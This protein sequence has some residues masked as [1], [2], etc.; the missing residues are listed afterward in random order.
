MDKIQKNAIKDVTNLSYKTL[1]S[2]KNINEI[3]NLKNE[4]DMQSD[5]ELET[6]PLVAQI[7]PLI[8]VSCGDINGIGLELILRNHKLISQYCK[9]IYCISM[10]LLQ[11]ASRLL[12]IAIASDLEV[13]HLESKGLSIQKG[14]AT[15]ESGAYSFDSF[16][17]A[18]E[19]SIAKNAGLLTLPINKYAWQLANIRY[20][21]HTEYLRKRFQKNA[22]MM[23][24]CEEMFV[25]LYTDHI[26][27]REVASSIQKDKLCDFLMQFYTSYSELFMMQQ[28]NKQEHYKTYIEMQSNEDSLNK[29]ISQH[30]KN[31]EQPPN[32]TESNPNTMQ[33]KNSNHNTTNTDILNQQK[34]ALKHHAISSK[35]VARLLET[36]KEQ[37]QINHNGNLAK[38]ITHTTKIE[39]SLQ[40]TTPPFEIAVLGVN[41]HAGDNGVLGHE[42]F[43][44]NECIKS[45]NAMIGKDVFVGAIAPDSA[46]IASNRMRFKAFVAMYH[47]SGLAPLKALYF[48]KSINV[49]LNLPIL[50]VSPDHGTGFDKA[51][52]KDSC[53]NMQSYLE[54]FKFLINAMT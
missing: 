54:C 10:D 8:Y 19:E 31:T 1:E 15:K 6:I 7:K 23:L 47:D 42:D 37:T 24:G 21:G 49:S 48:E 50:R 29:Q 51:Y 43:I 33:E 17:L 16:C 52:K 18:L 20:A 25:A 2:L 5:F 34:N 13:C 39:Q 32:I 36:D 4:K 30:K 53:L 26:P 27:L 40:N 11:Q 14:V 38:P 12:D 46:F 41:P 35:M 44:I 9:P 22:I 45:V 28:R 3:E